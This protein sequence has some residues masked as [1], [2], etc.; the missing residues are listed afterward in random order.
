MLAECGLDLGAMDRIELDEALPALPLAF[1]A[2]HPDL[3]ER[4]NLRGG[5]L[6]CGQAQG[7]AGARK[8][9]SLSHQLRDHRLRYG[10]V[11]A[12]TAGCGLALILER[13]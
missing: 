9:V 12:E 1:L 6:A 13:T 2:R 8:L 3:A 4:V 10:L 7:A 5:A 11:A